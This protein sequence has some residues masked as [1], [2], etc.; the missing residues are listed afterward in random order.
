[1]KKKDYNQPGDKAS[2]LVNYVAD[3]R[4]WVYDADDGLGGW[5]FFWGCYVILSKIKKH[6]NKT[7]LSDLRV[8]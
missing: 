4:W 7:H 6:K 5:G 3:L 1:M 2:G 8:K